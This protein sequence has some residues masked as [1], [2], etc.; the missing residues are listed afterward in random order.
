MP[1]ITHTLAHI[2][3]KPSTTTRDTLTIAR[4]IVRHLCARRE[5]IHTERQQLRRQAAKLRQFAPFTQQQADTLEQEARNHRATE[6]ESL[7]AALLGYGRLIL[8]DPDGTAEALGFDT[9]ADLL[10]INRTDREQARREGWHTL[11]ELVAIYALENSAERGRGERGEASPLYQACNLAIM[12][13][14]RECPPELLP[15]PFAPGG[16]FYGLPVR[17]MKPDGTLTTKRPALVV[18]DA[19]GSRV[20]ERPTL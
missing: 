14:I 19:A 6:L 16:P 5:V 4:R 9:L 20:V 2:G 17:V 11:A 13:F 12:E 1:A 10:N 7:R 15:D 18:H 3:L 8:N